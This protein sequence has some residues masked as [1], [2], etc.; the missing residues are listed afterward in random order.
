MNVQDKQTGESPTDFVRRC[1]CVRWINGEES[2]ERIKTAV[3]AVLA[4]NPDFASVSKIKLPDIPGIP[5]L[6]VLVSDPRKLPAIVKELLPVVEAD[7]R[8]H[9][10]SF[11]D[12]IRLGCEHFG[13]ALTPPVARLCR[14]R[15]SKLLSFDPAKSLVNA[16]GITRIKWRPRT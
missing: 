10:L 5:V 16:H 3:D 6:R 11:A 13:V 14:R 15:L 4:C 8:L 7:P 12:P 2:P 9:A 1:Y